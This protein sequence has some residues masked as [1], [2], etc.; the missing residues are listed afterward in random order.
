MTYT[1]AILEVTRAT[2]KE[3]ERKLRKAGYY[4]ALSGA[5]EVSLIDMNGIALEIEDEK[6]KG[7]VGV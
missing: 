1:Y 3:I 6:E 4:D 5:G 2:F 7:P